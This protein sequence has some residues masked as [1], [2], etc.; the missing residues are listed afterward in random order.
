MDIYAYTMNYRD[1][2]TDEEIEKV[3]D[4][5]PKVIERLRG[6]SPLWSDYKN[7]LRKSVIGGMAA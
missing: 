2:F 5:F 1:D 3:I 6:L 4:L 7:G